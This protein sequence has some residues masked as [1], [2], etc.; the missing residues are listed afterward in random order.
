MQREDETALEREVEREHETR[1]EQRFTSG[2]FTGLETDERA[3]RSM[4][5]GNLEDVERLADR[6]EGP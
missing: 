3:A 2:D 4:R 5:E 1:E 6:D